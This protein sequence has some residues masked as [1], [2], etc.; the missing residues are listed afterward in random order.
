V[1]AGQRDADL[2]QEVYSAGLLVG[3]LVD[4]ELAKLGIPQHLFSFLGW[5]SRLQP[6]TPGALAAE[7]GLPPTTVRDYVRRLVE[8]GDVRKTPNPSDGRSYHLVLTQKG[9]AVAARGWPAVVASYR[10]IAR[11][12]ERPAAEHLTSMRELRQAVKQ[13][14]AETRGQPEA[15]T[16]RAALERALF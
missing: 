4:E 5:V 11:H 14:L 15:P 13:A 1:S 7:T 8:R 3:M 12:L 16:N 9:Q 2:L 10:R 6:V